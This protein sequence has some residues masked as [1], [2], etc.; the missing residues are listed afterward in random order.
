MDWII[1]IIIVI[2]FLYIL[3][4]PGVLALYF[5]CNDFGDD[6]WLVCKIINKYVYL[7]S[8]KWIKSFKDR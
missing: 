1:E 4:L 6:K 8:F 7:L 5:L 2:C 3:T